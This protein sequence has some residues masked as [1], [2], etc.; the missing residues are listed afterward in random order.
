MISSQKLFT[1]L[2]LVLLLAG[3]TVGVAGA[4]SDL[5]VAVNDI[6][7]AVLEDEAAYLVTAYVTVADAEGDPVPNLDAGA[8]QVTQDGQGVELLSTKV[9]RRPASIV[10][11]LD[12]SGSMVYEDKMEAVKAAAA[13]FIDSLA[14]EDQLAVID[15]NDTVS[16]RQNL[17]VDH[18]AARSIIGLLEAKP[19]GGT[20]L[21]DAIYKGI[22]VASGAPEG[23]RAVLVLT[24]GIDET[25]SQSGPCSSESLSSVIEYATQETVGVPVY[26]IGVGNRVNLNELGSLA[27]Q[28]GGT[29]LAAAT[30]SDVSAQFTTVGEQLG[31]QYELVF[32]ST[33]PAGEHELTVVANVAGASGVDSRTF[34]APSLLSLSG[35]DEGALLEG[36]KTIRATL[37]GGDSIKE[38]IFSYGDEDVRV[39]EEPFEVLIDA[40]DLEP[41][42]YVLYAKADLVGGGQRVAMLSFEVPGGGMGS[43]FGGGSDQEGDAETETSGGGLPAWVLYGGI[44]LVVVAAGV[45]FFLSRGAGGAKKP[46]ASRKG[47]VADDSPKLVVVKSMNLPEGHE[48]VITK[49]RVTIGRSPDNDLIIPDS[50]VSR[51]HATIEKSG[52]SWRIIDEDSNYG[53]FVNGARATKQGPLGLSK[54]AEIQLGT[55][56]KLTFQLP[57]G[58]VSGSTDMTFDGLNETFDGLGLDDF[59]DESKDADSTFDE[60]EL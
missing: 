32:K 17:S 16:T 45:I 19:N 40:D 60:G 48:L 52:S 5:H 2:G 53:T 54:G 56:T 8:F 12:T 7:M 35:L 27:Q 9:V 37:G 58:Q 49:D 30:A 44:G 25:A 13:S 36:E 43:L 28:T 11:V 24:D 55:R 38:V 22:T 15:F 6:Q 31:N 4:Q 3:V 59:R 47:K 21:Y 23:L 34:I 26:T 50:P 41:G 33:L 29:A 1:T 14:E 18:Q 57:A 46:A 51:L 39:T 10:L 42:E 20:C